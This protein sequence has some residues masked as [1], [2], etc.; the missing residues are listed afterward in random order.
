MILTSDSPNACTDY[1]ISDAGQ[2][3]EMCERFYNTNFYKN[4]NKMKESIKTG[5]KLT[6]NEEFIWIPLSNFAAKIIVISFILGFIFLFFYG[7]IKLFKFI[8]FL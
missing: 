4:Q 5:R 1:C 6:W 8:W 2:N 7:V 3:C